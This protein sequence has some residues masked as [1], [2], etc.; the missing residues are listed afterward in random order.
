MN[1]RNISLTTQIKKVIGNRILFCSVAFM[2]IIFGLTIYDL[3]NSITQLRSRINEQIKPIEDFVIDQAMINNL[4]TVE[5]KVDSFNENNSTFKIEWVRK[6]TPVYKTITWRFP[7]RWIYD[8]QINN[9]AGYHFG[10]FK[11]S[12]GFLSDKTLIYDLILRL[13]LLGIFTGSII[14]ILFPLAKKIPEQLFIS[15]INRFIDLVSNNSVHS[16]VIAKELPVELE[17]LETKILA[18]LKT[19]TEHERNKATTELGHLSARLA[20]DIRSPLSAMEMGLRQ[21]AKKVPYEELKV[22]T[23]GIQSVR[24]IADNVLERYRNPN[25]DINTADYDDG[26][27]IRPILLLTLTEMMISQKRHE[28]HQQPCELILTA[29][30]EAKISW[31]EAAPNEVKR[32]L[33][34]LLNNGYDALME[35]TGVIHIML[36]AIND[37]LQLQ[38]QDNGIGIPAEKMTDVLNGMSLKHVGQ[39][40]GLSMARQ[41]MESLAG[42]LNITSTIGEGTTVS[43]IFPRANIL[44]WFPLQI[45]LQGINTV[46]VLDD[47]F[48]MLMYWQQ[49]ISDAGLS[50][51]LFSTYEK[52]LQWV[53][54]NKK[55]ATSTIFLADY[56]LAEK[57]TNG[58]M[59]LEKIDNNNNCY[60]ITSHAEEFHF[61]KAAEKAGVWLIPKSLA[62]EISLAL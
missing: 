11:V 51:K 32:L 25:T 5:L 21:L 61:Q 1:T 41:Y 6:G 58:L 29:Q 9:V 47:D 15:P 30:P 56:E 48:S 46:M 40:L 12:G 19:A 4:G 20:H 8:Y 38:L 17:V 45:S 60:L 26:N 24:G 13:V 35:S 31:I 36:S 16:D 49:R 37:K 28:W 27:R 52:A 18:L 54:D 53:E 3:S 62:S 44:P 2:M 55:L 39:G 23:S 10:Y 14:I 22:L 50:P 57:T 59:L 7:F 33:S 43:L 34:N 42:K